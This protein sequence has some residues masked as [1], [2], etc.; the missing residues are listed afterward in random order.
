MQSLEPM[1][2]A[3]ERILNQQLV[4]DNS[5]VLFKTPVGSGISQSGLMCLGLQFYALG[6]STLFTQIPEESCRE[7]NQPPEML[8]GQGQELG[9]RL[10]LV[11]QP[12]GPLTSESL[13][14]EGIVH[15]RP[16]DPDLLATFS[17]T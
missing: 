13:G 11:G 9:V 3:Q 15:W 17:S 8:M 7:D 4:A 10:G 12:S 5:Q 14:A 1:L 16:T 6:S 2:V